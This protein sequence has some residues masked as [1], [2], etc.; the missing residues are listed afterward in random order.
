VQAT[1]W[2]REHQ[3]TNDRDEQRENEA[4]AIG[5]HF[6][7]GSATRRERPARARTSQ[8]E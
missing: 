6:R 2:K 4:L 8:P 5:R 3:V 1:G 7:A